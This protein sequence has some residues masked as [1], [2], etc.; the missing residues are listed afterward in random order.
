VTTRDLCFIRDVTIVVF[1]SLILTGCNSPAIQANLNDSEETQVRHPDWSHNLT[2][3]EVNVRQYTAEGTFEGFRSHL[4]RLKEMG[5]GILWLM[6]IHPIGEKNRKGTLGSY[7]SVKDYY[8][9]NA[10]FGTT[11][12]LKAL[13]EEIHE[14]GMY[15]ILDWVANHTAWDNNLTEEHPEWYERDSD[16][17]FILPVPDWSDVIKLDYSADGL[18]EYM[19]NAM[20]YWVEEVGVDGF[21][22]D[23]AEMVPLTFWEL[24]REE[25]EKIKP[26]FFLA[27]GNAP[28][29]HQKAFDM[30][31]SWSLFNILNQM[32]K[33]EKRVTDLENFLMEDRKKY[34]AGS[35]RMLFTTNHDENSWNGTT[36]ERLGNA[37][38]VAA[39]LTSTLEGMPLVYSGQEAGLNKRLAFF[40][41][42]EIEWK[43]HRLAT[44][45]QRLFGLKQENKVM[46]N[47]GQ[48]GEVLRIRTSNDDLVFA[49]NRQNDMNSLVV[50]PNLSDVSLKITLNEGMEP[51]VYTDLFSGEEME[52]KAGVELTLDPWG[53]RVF[54]R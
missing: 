9:V 6:P 35:F 19:I 54:F 53:Y 28:E 48:G 18:N 16:G 37:A 47:G 46:W 24:A 42:D 22:C 39:V 25:L 14:M 27:E 2:I 49:F 12:E 38:E 26:L 17:N 33:R 41:K 36:H 34:P 7:Y 51:S 13:V 1:C 10:E 23:V 11:A 21:R 44:V 45:Y 29:L 30:T 31:Y 8:G 40:E 50:I 20:K 43:E 5:V 4:P 52:L 3:Y 32:A 15:V